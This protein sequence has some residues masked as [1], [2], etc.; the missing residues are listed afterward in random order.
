MLWHLSLYKKIFTLK[1]LKKLKTILLKGFERKLLLT[2]KRLKS[3][4]MGSKKGK[5]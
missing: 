1:K 4:K 3:S 5:M 2:Y